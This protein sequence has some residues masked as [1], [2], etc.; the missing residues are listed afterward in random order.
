MPDPKQRIVVVS[1]DKQ[2]EVLAPKITP[3]QKAQQTEKLLGDLETKVKNNKATNE[4]IKLY[5]YNVTLTNEYNKKVTQLAANADNFAPVVLDLFN[6]DYSKLGNYEGKVGFSAQ[7]GSTSMPMGFTSASGDWLTTLRKNETTFNQSKLAFKQE[8]LKKLSNVQDYI[9]T[10]NYTKLREIAN[11]LTGPSKEVNNFYNKKTFDRTNRKTASYLLSLAQAFEYEK[12]AVDKNINLAELKNNPKGLKEIGRELYSKEISSPLYGKYKMGIHEL[13]AKNNPDNIIDYTATKLAARSL[14]TLADLDYTKKLAEYSRLKLYAEQTKNTTGLKQ[15]E[16]ALLA[17]EKGL[18]D[19]KKFDVNSILKTQ[20]KNTY[21]KEKEH[22]IETVKRAS[23]SGLLEIPTK[24]S[25]ALLAGIKSTLNNL[26]DTYYGAQSFLPLDSSKNALYSSLGEDYKDSDLSYLADINKFDNT[27]YTIGLDENGN[28]VESTKFRWVDSKGKAHYNGYAIIESGLPVA[29]QMIESILLSKGIGALGRGVLGATS[30]LARTVVG[31]DRLANIGQTVLNT[32]LV[33]SAANFTKTTLSNPEVFN[34]LTTFASVYATTYPRIY[35]EEYDNFKNPEDARNVANLRAVVESIS[36]SYVPNTPDLWRKGTKGLFGAAKKD[37]VRDLSAGLDNVVLDIA[38]GASN[39]FL[40]AIK[41]S[42]ISRRALGI[43]GDVIQEGVIEEEASLIGNYFVD[44]YA[45]SKNQDYVEQNDLSAKNILDTAIESTAAMLLTAPFMGGGSARSKKARDKEEIISARWNIA[46][47]PDLYKSVIASRVEAKE[48]TEEEGAKAI[49][50][51]DQYVKALETLPTKIGS[52]RDMKSLLEDKDAQ[53]Q[54][55]SMHLKKQAL[56]DYTPT[57]EELPAYRE[58]LKKLDTELYKTQELAN[59]YDNLSLT[60]KR[61]IITDNFANKLNRLTQ[62]D[63]FSPFAL[64]GELAQAEKDLRENKNRVFSTELGQHVANLK[65]SMELA[66]EKFKNFSLNNNEGLTF[67]QYQY[68]SGM[69]Y[70][71]KEFFTEEEN[72]AMM[73]S[74]RAG[75]TE[76]VRPLFSIQNENDFLE[77]LAK[78]YVTAHTNKKPLTSNGEL[79]YEQITEQYVDDALFARFTQGLPEE[80]AQK[81]NDELKNRFWTRVVELKQ[82]LQPGQVFPEVESTPEVTTTGTTQKTTTTAAPTPAYKQSLEDFREAADRGMTE[83]M[84][85][86]RDGV[87]DKLSEEATAESLMQALPGL[88]SIF[89]G[90]NLNDIV[91]DLQQGNT[92]SLAEFL[93]E[94]GASPK[95]VETLVNKFAQ[96]KTA[97]TT[98]T[99]ETAETSTEAAIEAE[100]E[101]L[102]QEKEKALKPLIE[103]KE[104]IEKEIA[105]I[106]KEEKEKEDTFEN[107]PQKDLEIRSIQETAKMGETLLAMD[108]N[109]KGFKQLKKS[110]ERL[111]DAFVEAGYKIILPYES[112]E[113]YEVSGDIN[114]LQ[115]G[116]TTIV[117]PVIY[118]K[119]TLVQKGKIVIKDE[120]ASKRE[121][122]NKK[123]E[124]NEEE[125]KT[126]KQLKEATKDIDLDKEYSIDEVENILNK[127]GLSKQ[128]RFIFN[129]IKNVAKQL[130]VTVS[131]SDGHNIDRSNNGTYSLK[132]HEIIINLYGIIA[133]TTT[134]NS[135][136]ISRVVVHEIVHGVTR[137][138]TFVYSATKGGTKSSEL[139]N[140]DK[141]ALTE[142]QKVSIENLL[143][144]L[145][146]LQVDPNFEGQYG[147]TNIDELLA[148]LT[149]EEFVTK[150][151]NKKFGNTNKSFFDKILD[152]LSKL[153]GIEVKDSN[154]YEK[155]L[156]SLQALLLD[157]NI[158]TL[159][160]VTSNI[161]GKSEFKRLTLEEAFKERTKTEAFFNEITNQLNDLKTLALEFGLDLNNIS[162]SKSERNNASTLEQLKQKLAEV[163]R[164]INEVAKSFNSQIVEKKTQLRAA[165]QLAT[166]SKTETSQAGSVGVGEDVKSKNG[167][168]STLITEKENPNLQG[169]AFIEVKD[170]NGKVIGTIGVLTNTGVFEKDGKKYASISGISTTEEFRGKG[171]GIELYR[172]AFEQIKKLGFEGLY[173]SNDEVV[174][175]KRVGAIRNKLIVENLGNGEYLYLGVKAVEQSLKETSQPATTEKVEEGE[176]EPVTPE[177]AKEAEVIEDSLEAQEKDLQ[178][179]KTNQVIENVR[180][181]YVYLGIK[182]TNYKDETLLGDENVAFVFAFIDRIESSISSADMRSLGYNY[183]MHSGREVLNRLG[184]DI[185]PKDSFEEFKEQ[186]RINGILVLP[187]EEIFKAF[188][189][190]AYLDTVKLGMVTNEKGEPLFF[191]KTGEKVNEG[192]PIVTAIGQTFEREQGQGGKT[193]DEQFVSTIPDGGQIAPLSKFVNGKVVLKLPITAAESNRLMM[194]IG[195]EELVTVGNKTYTLHPGVIYLETGNPKVPYRATYGAINT[196]ES[197]EDIYTL[198]EEYNKARLN[199][200]ESTLS[201]YFSTMSPKEFISYLYNYAFIPKGSSRSKWGITPVIIKGERNVSI[202]RIYNNNNKQTS[203]SREDAINLIATTK[204]APTK[205]YFNGDFRFRPFRIQNGKVETGKVM[206][207]K[208]WFGNFRLS[209]AR[210]DTVPNRNIAFA[211]Q[212][213]RPLNQPPAVVITPADIVASNI[214]EPAPLS[215]VGKIA[216]ASQEFKQASLVDLDR[217]GGFRET[218]EDYRE[219]ERDDRLW[220]DRGFLGRGTV[221]REETKPTE[222]AEVT[223]S[224]EEREEQMRLL[225]EEKQ[226]KLDPLKQELAE[227]STQ[228]AQIEKLEQEKVLDGLVEENVTEEE[229][230]AIAQEEGIEKEAVKEKIKEEVNN[231]INNVKPSSP[232]GAALQKVINKIL[233]AFLLIGLIINLNFANLSFKPSPYKVTTPTLKESVQSVSRDSSYNLLT[234]DGKLAYDQEV[235][236]KKSFV[237]VDKPTAQAYIYDNTG[238]L[239]KSFPVLLGQTVGDELNTADVTKDVAVNAY[240]TPGRYVLDNYVNSRDLISYENRILG[241]RNGNGIAIH[242]TS[243]NQFEKRTKALNTPSKEDNRLSWGCVNVS[244]ENWDAYIKDNIKAG[245]YIIITRDFQDTSVSEIAKP[246]AKPVTKTAVTTTTPVKKAPVSKEG[247]F[248]IFIASL[249]ALVERK[250][251]GENID[252]EL[253]ALKATVVGRVAAL[254]KE[255]ERIEND[256]NDRITRIAQGEVLTPA[257]IQETLSKLPNDIREEFKGKFIY[258]TPGAGKTTLAQGMQG[259]VDTDVLI[260]EEMKKRHPDFF[261][262]ARESMQDFIFRYV[263]TH[264]HKAEINNIVLDQAKSLASQGNTVLTGTIAFIKDADIVLT[265]PVTNPRI[266]ERFKDTQTANAFVAKEA[267]EIKKAD[268]TAEALTNNLEFFLTNKGFVESIDTPDNLPTIRARR[269]QGPVSLERSKLYAK[270]VTEAQEEA[271]KRWVETVG[272]KAFGENRYLVEQFLT[273]PKAWA[274]WSEAAGMLLFADASFADLYHESWHEFSQLYFTPEQREALYKTAAKIYGKLSTQELEERIAEDFRQFMLTGVIPESIQKYKDARTTFQK[275]ADFLRNLFS[276][277]KTVD[278]YFENLAKGRVGKKVGKAEFGTLNSAKTLSLHN[279]DEELV[280]LSYQESKRY[281]D[282]ID[283]MFVQIGNEVA[284]QAKAEEIKA[285]PE[286]ARGISYINLMYTPANI[287]AV[288]NQIFNRFA[289]LEDKAIAKKDLVAQQELNKIFGIKD[290]NIKEI[291]RYHMLNSSMFTEDMVSELQE[292]EEEELTDTNIIKDELGSKSQLELTPP[293]VLNVIRSIPK[294]NSEGKVIT[295]A[296]TGAPEFG[297][298]TENWN[299]LKNTLSGATDYAE[300]LSRIEKLTEEYPQF[301][302]LLQTLPVKITLDSAQQLR[303]LFFNI[304]SLEKV[305]GVTASFSKEGKFNVSNTGTLDIKRVRD[306]WALQFSTEKTGKY[307][308]PSAITGNFILNPAIF[309]AYPEVPR[310]PEDVL[311]FLEEIGFNYSVKAQQA[312]IKDFN[313]LLPKFQYVYEKLKD[314]TLSGG[315]EISDPMLAIRQEHVNQT[316]GKTIK[317]KTYDLDRLV[318][319]ESLNN[320]SFANDMVQ[321]ADGTSK[322]ITTQA[323]YQTK[324]IAALNNP[325]YKYFEDLFE[326]YPELDPSKNWGLIGSAYLEYLFDFTE[327]IF[328]NGKLRHK[329]NIIDG[330]PVSLKIVSLNGVTAEEDYGFNA[331]TI[332]L[333]D[334]EK[335]LGDIRTLLSPYG[336]VEENNRIGEKSTTRGLMLSSENLF[337]YNKQFYYEG[338]DFFIKPDVWNIIYKYLEAEAKITDKES[339]FGNFNKNK[340]FEGVPQLAYFSEILSP[341][342]RTEVYEYFKNNTVEDFESSALKN[343]VKKEVGAWIAEA[344]NTSQNLLNKFEDYKVQEKNNDYQVDFNELQRYHTLSMIHRIEQYKLFNYHPYY[345]K[346]AKDVEKR[347]P[348]FNANGTFP[349]IDQDNLDYTNSTLTTQAAFEKFAEQ[350]GIEVLPRKGTQEDITYLVIEDTALDSQTARENKKDYGIH[351]NSYAETKKKVDV[352]DAASLITLDFFRKFYALSKGLTN[353]MKKE[354]DR[355]ST[356]WANLLEVKVNPKNTEAREA[357]LKALNTPAHYIFS[358]K[359]LQYAGPG[360]TE[361]EVVPVFHKYSNKVILPSE[362]VDSEELFNIAVKLHASN[363]DYLVFSTGTKIAETVKPVSLFYN[364]KVDNSAKEPG[365]ISLRYL[366]EQQEMEHKKDFLTIFATQFRKLLFKDLTTQEEKDLFKVYKKYIKQLT[367]H[368]MNSFLAKVKDKEAAV[369]FLIKELDKKNV[370]AI[371]K[372]LIRIKEENGELEYAIDSL[373]ERTMAEAAVTSAL[374]KSFIRQKF[375]GT[376]F[377]QFPVSL[378]RPDKKLKFYRIEEG[379]IAS[380]EA[381]ISF[382]KKYYSLLDLP[383]DKNSTIGQVKREGNSEVV[384]NPYSALK[385]LNQKLADPAF[386]KKYQ[387]SLTLAGVRIPVQGYNSMEKV[388]IVEFLPEESGNMILVPDELVV[389]SG[390]DFD[391]DKLFMY[392]PVLR[393]GRVLTYENSYIK[394]LE[395]LLKRPEKKTQ[396]ELQEE[397]TMAEMTVEEYMAKTGFTLGTIEEIKQINSRIEFL[398]SSIETEKRNLFQNGL[399]YTITKRLS[400][401][402]IFMDLIEPNNVKDLDEFAKT[403][404][405]YLLGDTN[406]IIKDSSGRDMWSNLINP[407]YQLY[408][409]QLAQVME[410]VG[411]AAKANTFQ[412]AVQ[413]AELEIIDKD[414]IDLIYFDVN[415]D[416][417]GNIK[418]WEIY[419][420]DKNNKISQIISQFISGF[421]DVVKNDNILKNNINPNTTGV[422]LYL[423]MMGVR[424]K[425]INT[426]LKDE[427]I[428]LFS[429]GQSFRDI[430]LE[431][432]PAILDDYTV[433]NANGTFSEYKTAVNILQSIDRETLLTDDT[434]KGS[435][436]RLAQFVILKSQQS[437]YVTPLIIGTDFD[438]QS[439][440]NFE[441]ITRKDEDINEIYKS[442]FFNRE[443][444]DKLIYD[445]TVSSFRVDPSFLDSFTDLFPIS[446]NRGLIEFLSV[447]HKKLGKTWIDYDNFSRRF[448]NALVT[449]ILETNMQEFQEYATY[450]RVDPT[451]KNAQDLLTEIRKE[452]AENGAYIPLLDSVYFVGNINSDYIAPAVFRNDNNLDVDVKKEQFRQNLEWDSNREQ[453]VT[454][455]FRN[456]VRNFFRIFAYTGIISSQ[457]N[458]SH[459]SFLEIIPETIYTPVIDRY[460]KET[461]PDIE[462]GRGSEYL[463]KFYERFRYNNPDIFIDRYTD[464]VPNPSLKFYRNYDLDVPSTIVEQEYPNRVEKVKPTPAPAPVLNENSQIAQTIKKANQDIAKAEETLEEFN[465]NDVSREQVTTIKVISD[466]DLEYFAD[467]VRKSKGTYPPEFF[468]SKTR[469]KEFYN[470]QTGRRENAPQSSKWIRQE[471]GLYDLVDKET[472]EVYITGV[473]LETGLKTISVPKTISTDLFPEEAQDKTV[474]ERI[475]END[476]A[477][478]PDSSDNTSVDDDIVDDIN[479]QEDSECDP[480]T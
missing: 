280:P 478:N 139:Y 377:V 168:T 68:K 114:K 475:K 219:Q 312:F 361:T 59:K 88:Q 152:Y 140:V 368:D 4:E 467:Y 331:K 42:A 281:L 314:V 227:L 44:K 329:R 127:L 393:N 184:L 371:T 66:K 102:R 317:G 453:D 332:D 305:E 364:G 9:N 404:P 58:E 356:I 146:L 328:V 109:E 411:V 440:R 263:K 387:D 183:L 266:K 455:Q 390:G 21:F 335:H 244:K 186:F 273:D 372:D 452:A 51:V 389:K 226:T 327:G 334:P 124:L 370:S 199:P 417:D 402:E 180:E 74:I 122:Q 228:L 342:L 269:G 157:P 276:N 33:G 320:L 324:V 310:T 161:K 100:I 345:Y 89:L 380:A 173:S 296:L 86:V 298:F 464:K 120:L 469:F 70:V 137:Y 262:E 101:K 115:E 84:Q 400:Q 133:S 412:A 248:A 80:E 427:A 476:R 144:L 398:E 189:T 110:I 12:I 166:T 10:K 7:S 428:Y 365:V 207:Y 308:M 116:N 15:A 175:K 473:N 35:M 85:A 258:V 129:L 249:A 1:G 454:E 69:A 355:Q 214:T 438:T 239:I 385:R 105:E 156:L 265:M 221:R 468:T 261:A 350:K 304:M 155:V 318:E 384:V 255:I 363:A 303:N 151:K 149:N 236:L 336:R 408:V 63:D 339:I 150:L 126:Q 292:M 187:Q 96:E 250:R 270:Q 461:A 260:V 103:E 56:L 439:V 333:A 410:M 25:Y 307:K 278:R 192:T 392:E 143:N 112:L 41:E 18:Q 375:N 117:S 87:I 53:Y 141:N 36:E 178:E 279:E 75:L 60:D 24:A 14:Q 138:L 118:Y 28:P 277:K 200:E 449:S 95:Q 179:A 6:E 31:G 286:A 119:G 232:L 94:M 45:K 162:A 419:D 253:E 291:S 64:A 55:F 123:T 471:N 174:D 108:S 211:K 340:F 382:S 46:N 346:N 241:L 311:S 442:D 134:K 450:L 247:S 451:I 38:P 40:K 76:S 62:Q 153:F 225:E 480:I 290:K 203:V 284:L 458:K 190:P 125:V 205:E 34:R 176:V 403:A 220:E 252:A 383:F 217:A 287:Q 391:I 357:L 395:N 193:F 337:L 413:D 185:Q 418:L 182:D 169:K 267:A 369:E 27:G 457:L 160:Q 164:K 465:P 289:D 170:S 81:K 322:F 426:F 462:E 106:E 132:G 388:E 181:N 460:I 57:E 79:L 113:N 344:A 319:L 293:L 30:S 360:K 209:N 437:K 352:Q 349:V 2:P 104:Q 264:D 424:Y 257:R 78:N 459:G 32:P 348:S 447:A 240:T 218:L 165:Q 208:T 19:L 300:M 347:I 216:E 466:Q 436:A 343:L 432:S 379:K 268:R 158:Q 376:Q 8:S 295:N 230:D 198:I 316:T 351:Y 128:A 242:Q 223:P 37:Y 201:D 283:E 13:S 445:S 474:D 358:V 301:E 359:K 72:E 61:K 256:Y 20:F 212:D 414:A 234:L 233:K 231:S 406:K 422:A 321:V 73:S 441:S 99:T 194:H 323:T 23:A 5:N 98:E 3:Q 288:Y 147:L 142:V 479:N 435:L 326:E 16:E 381:M 167:I 202:V 416:E 148:E 472:G 54:F 197:A 362:M 338:N 282:M 65:A 237:L 275:I 43:A 254:T 456:K 434:Y 154:Y 206:N 409:Y 210:I 246:V 82:N 22:E 67:E 92:A 386:R 71:N 396:E 107:R 285:N 399:L 204:A 235:K 330:K 163:N 215:L 431:T 421:V 11:Y 213:V 367:N 420:V 297:D 222:A 463:K 188:K 259:V 433:L 50:K 315:F 294:V 245:D 274:K 251:K 443:A 394:Q 26:V 341:E 172:Q 111:F 425:D 49:A 177:E 171:F 243:K 238:S 47:N 271:A 90:T 135:S 52:I 366:K 93:D 39:K 306:A 429:K 224:T 196:R 272:K 423:N 302:Y 407:H 313:K 415:M 77:A 378:V 121:N 444:L 17:S 29:E 448:K 397:S 145:A 191:D 354:L 97:G 83:D 353:D 159:K 446:A 299:I 136:N 229:I 309:T 131:F 130:G 373:I 195:K 470:P 48:I 374:K 405:E 401:K 325:K 91:S 477:V 430:I